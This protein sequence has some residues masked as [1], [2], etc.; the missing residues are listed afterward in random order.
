MTSYVLEITLRT[1][2]TSA[3]GEGRVGLV[4]RDVVFDDYDYLSYQDGV[5]KA[6]G[7][8]RIRR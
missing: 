8:R 1:P 2:L 6:S 7:V 3:A 5:S 4:D